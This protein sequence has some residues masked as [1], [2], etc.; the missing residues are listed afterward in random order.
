MFRRFWERFN[1]LKRKQHVEYP[2]ESN[3]QVKIFH[4]L[5]NR[6]RRVSRNEFAANFGGIA[7]DVVEMLNSDQANRAMQEARET[8]ERGP[9]DSNLPP[10]R[11]VEYGLFSEARELEKGEVAAI[12]GTFALP[13][14][15][16]SAG[17]AICVGI[18]SL[19]HRRPMQESL[20]YWSS[21]VLLSDAVDTDD[22][23]AREKLGLFG[24]YPTAYLRYYEIEH[25]LE[26]DEP[27]LFLDGPLVDEY[28]V[29]IK[30][31]RQLYNRLFANKERQALG[32]I[33]NIANPVFTKFARALNSG[34]VYVV[35]TVA[36][37]LNQSNATRNRYVLDRFTNG[38]ARD[39][40]RGVFKPRNKAFGFEVH[41]DHLEDML[42]IMA[43]DCQMNNPGHE[44]PFLLNRV[45]EE[46]RK[47]FSPRI[48]KD[49][50][51]VKMATQSEELFFEETDERSFRSHL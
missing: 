27:Y 49:R 3:G 37:H 45:D 2:S 51:A 50:I 19:S 29:S 43:A 30:A 28:L 17:Q 24:I 35:E 26:I 22:F 20:H 14:Q 9:V 21:K 33:K 8:M 40:F 12:D 44:I 42:R 18:G 31:G 46:V 36:N 25:C 41:E 39:I 32:V 15:K 10:L 47:N 4:E 13:M 7:D 34:E 48:L 5:L 1:P 6:S 16:Y 11:K 23:I 38:I